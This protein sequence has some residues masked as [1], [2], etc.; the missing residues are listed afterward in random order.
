MI[1]HDYL[2][3]V[4]RAVWR[5]LWFV[6]DLHVGNN[7]FDEQDFNK[8]AAAIDGDEHARWIFM[9]DGAECINVNDP[10]FKLE[11]IPAY[12]RQYLE[13]LP[14]VQVNY[15][16]KLFEPI[17]NKCIG[18]H[19]GNHEESILTHTKSFDPM[20]DYETLF[21]KTAKNLGRG[22][23]GTRIRFKDGKHV[24]TVKVF[25]T[26]GYTMAVTEGAKFNKLKELAD[27]FPNFDFY[28]MGHVH[29]LAVD[30]EPALDLPAKGELHLVERER[31]F[32]LSGCYF[33]TYQEGH[34]SYG[35]VRNYRAT[36][37]GSPYIKIKFAGKRG[38]MITTF[39]ME[40]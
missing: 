32:V 21:P 12:F 25:T 22:D 20:F 40:P 11:N 4:P 14:Q 16:C 1:L 18:Y 24:D 7:G 30:Q 35:E 9:G 10:R 33:K 28:G 23:G 34:A 31:T 6:G 2:W 19:A 3:K 38:E 27:S 5:T 29:K 37:I 15:V 17:K 26:H 8:I 36:R 39:G 13:N